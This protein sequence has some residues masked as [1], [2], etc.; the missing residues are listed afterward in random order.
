MA[1]SAQIILVI[2]SIMLTPIG[3]TLKAAREKRG[4]SLLDAAHE[5]R[6]PVARLHLLEQ[7]NYAA[8]GSMT[9]AR[10]FLRRYSQYLEVD[11]RQILQDLPGG[12][13]GGPRDYRYL[14]ENHG[15]WV[16]PR[17]QRLGYLNPAVAKARSR[18]SPVP[19]GVFVFALVLAGTGIWGKYVAEDRLVQQKVEAAAQPLPEVPAQPLSASASPAVHPRHEPTRILKAIP[20]MEAEVRAAQAGNSARVE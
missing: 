13:L 4:L 9:Y 7:D 19:A 20:V 18:R 15:L 16:A 17:G 1:E 2:Y 3:Q 5:T 8:F 6:I 12:V 10:S 14:T 11:A